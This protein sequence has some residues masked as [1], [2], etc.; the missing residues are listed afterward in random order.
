MEQRGLLRNWNDDKGFGF[1]QPERGGAELFAHI[2]AMRGD[3]RPVAGDQ[4]MYIAG[5]DAQGRPRAEHIRLAGELALDRPAIRRKPRV[6]SSVAAPVA[7]PATK[8]RA[9]QK[10][11]RDGGPIQHLSFKLVL[12]A[13]LCA[14]PVWG[15]WQ[16]LMQYGAVWGLVV[17]PL[18]SLLSFLQYWRD[19][20]SAQ[21][22]RWRTPENILHIV[23]LLG[24]WPGA[25][26]A[27]QCFRHKTR[28]LS[29]QLVFWLI[30]AAHQVLLV[31]WLLLDGQLL[32]GVLQRFLLV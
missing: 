26:V 22:G 21:A 29:F 31:D 11:A 19:K 1:I 4:V 17:Y 14:L 10:P 6:A 27:L 13:A 8:P 9:R 28:K 18:A 15:S 7:K 2:S 25:L 20:S 12:L 16:L 30:I 3:R 5:K 32:S 23:E 24:G